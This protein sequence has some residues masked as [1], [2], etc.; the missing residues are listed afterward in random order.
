[1]TSPPSSVYQHTMETMDCLSHFSV[2]W[3]SCWDM[4]PLTVNTSHITSTEWGRRKEREKKPTKWA[5]KFAPA[6]LLWLIHPSNI[7]EKTSP[8]SN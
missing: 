5:R 6:D 1:M 8:S 4:G 2:K 7:P 3:R